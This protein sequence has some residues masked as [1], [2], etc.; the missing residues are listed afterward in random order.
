[1]DSATIMSHTPPGRA[2]ASST[3]IGASLAKNHD[4]SAG[5]QSRKLR[6]A[7]QAGGNHAGATHAADV[8]GSGGLAAGLKR[9]LRFADE[10]FPFDDSDLDREGEDSQGDLDDYEDEDYASEDTTAT[11]VTPFSTPPGPS[12]GF[13]VARSLP[14]SMMGGN[15]GGAFGTGQPIGNV[16][17]RGRHGNGDEMAS[18]TDEGFIA[19]HTLASTF[20]ATVDHHVWYHGRNIEDN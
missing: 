17:G 3:V 12:S 11:D 2:R 16:F 1:M 13:Q 18:N 19:P 20:R 15:H 10:L 9:K 5:Q 4:D 14:V 6:E 8:A 7:D